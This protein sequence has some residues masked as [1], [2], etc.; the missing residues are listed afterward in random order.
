[1]T[2]TDKA[3]ALAF[4]DRLAAD[5]LNPELCR[6]FGIEIVPATEP[7]NAPEPEPSHE[8]AGQVEG[9]SLDRNEAIRRIK[10]AL[11]SRSGK[12]WSVT[13]GRG[14]AWG[15]I[16]IDTMPA[17]K[18]FDWDGNPTESEFGYTSKEEQSELA[19][20]L[21]VS[22]MHPQGIDIPSGSYYREVSRC[23][24]SNNLRA[25]VERTTQVV[26]KDERRRM[27]TIALAG[28]PDIGQWIGLGLV[29][30]AGIYARW[31]WRNR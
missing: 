28:Y 9:E 13:G 30:A 8:P 6:E 31:C 10:A 12:S 24:V 15:W 27:I 3:S 23:R 18:R 7:E 4:L 21:G 29:I 5:P 20:L 11:K 26:A 2:I 16:K 19:A 1:M 17:R 22:R 14:T 25:G